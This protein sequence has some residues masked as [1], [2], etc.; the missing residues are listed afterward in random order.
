MQNYGKGGLA[1]LGMLLA[2]GAAVP[3]WAAAA[4]MAKDQTL[5]LGVLFYRAYN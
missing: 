1:G 5:E 3:A 4:G 2:L